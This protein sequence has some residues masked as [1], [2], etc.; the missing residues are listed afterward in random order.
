MARKKWA[1]GKIHKIY[2]INLYIA[3]FDLPSDCR[4]AEHYI[5]KKAHNLR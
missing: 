4:C 3:F 2:H 5:L 1:Y